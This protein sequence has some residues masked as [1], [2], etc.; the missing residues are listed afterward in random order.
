MCQTCST[1]VFA[2]EALPQWKLLLLSV[3]LRF[4]R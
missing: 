4:S 3:R 1:I 2:T